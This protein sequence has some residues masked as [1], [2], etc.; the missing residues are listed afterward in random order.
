MIVPVVTDGTEF[1]NYYSKDVVRQM[2]DAGA[3]LHL[4]GIGRFLHSE[5]HV[6]RANGR[7]C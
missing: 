4:V 3:Q 2:A 7:S 1:T 5:E 6:D